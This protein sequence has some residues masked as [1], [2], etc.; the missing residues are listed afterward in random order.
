[1]PRLE[2]V[3]GGFPSAPLASSS[4]VSLVL[5]QS[6]TMRLL[7]ESATARVSIVRSVLGIDRGVGGEHREHRGHRRREHRRALGHATDRGDHAV[8]HLDLLD[9]L[10]AH[11]VG[12][13][14]RGGG[15]RATGGVGA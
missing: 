7:N 9:R 14:D 1:M 13:E 6:S 4:T 12:G 15:R 5:V 2:R 10:L 3:I 8:R 11:G